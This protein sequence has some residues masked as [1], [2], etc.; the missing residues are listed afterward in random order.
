MKSTNRGRTRATSSALTTHHHSDN[1]H[2]SHATTH[3]EP[4]KALIGLGIE[5]PVNLAPLT[6]DDAAN[7]LRAVAR[8][9][10]VKVI[11]TMDVETISNMIAKLKGH[12]AFI[13]WLVAGVQAGRRPSDLVSDNALL[14]DF[15]MSN[16][17]DQLSEETRAVLRSMQVLQGPRSQAELAYI[18]NVTATAIQSAL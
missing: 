15:C 10:E 13:K 17:Y 4:N 3:H 6:D 18:N 2:E 12:P 14:L 1:H 7:L 5:N 11:N 16:V 8:I 9:R